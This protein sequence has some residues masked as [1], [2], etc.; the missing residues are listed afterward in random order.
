[1]G[2]GEEE[3]IE[4]TSY[5]A[6]WTECMSLWLEG[7]APDTDGRILE[8]LQNVGTNIIASS[9]AG[10]CVLEKGGS[11]SLCSEKI[12]SIRNSWIQ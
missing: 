4:F 3:R 8:S 6:P 12:E 9:P 11:P 2:A 10:Q 1:M 5:P 7:W